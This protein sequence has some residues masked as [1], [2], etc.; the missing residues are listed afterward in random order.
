MPPE[1]RS[2]NPFSQFLEEPGIGM[3]AA[4]MARR[5]TGMGFGQE[6]QFEDMFSRF[7]NQYLGTLG[8]QI[9]SGEAPTAR[10]DDFLGGLNIPQQMASMAPASRGAGIAR[11]APSTT[12]MPF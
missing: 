3:R 9:M 6:R 4:Y 11:F 7:Q 10:W 1:E 5:P 8:Q 12:F 2:Y